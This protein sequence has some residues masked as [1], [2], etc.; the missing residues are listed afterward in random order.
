MKSLIMAG[1]KHSRLRQGDDSNHLVP[2]CGFTLIERVIRTAFEAGGE[3]LY[4]LLRH[5]LLL[6]SCGTLRLFAYHGSSQKVFL[7]IGV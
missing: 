4:L 5:S 7:R 6:S 1:G 3:D 2:L